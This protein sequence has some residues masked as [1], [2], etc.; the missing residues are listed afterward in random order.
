L[1]NWDWGGFAKEVVCKG[2]GGKFLPIEN[3]LVARITL[4]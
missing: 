2:S 1:K 3:N 4:V